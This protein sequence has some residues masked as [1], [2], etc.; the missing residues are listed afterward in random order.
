MGSAR[1]FGRQLK[2][3]T[4]RRKA[5]PNLLPVHAPLRDTGDFSNGDDIQYE[6][7]ESSLQTPTPNIV[8]SVLLVKPTPDSR[9]SETTALGRRSLETGLESEFEGEF[10]Q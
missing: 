9:E 1:Q 4:S 8:A 7:Q 5:T 6:R 10:N 2:K 3:I